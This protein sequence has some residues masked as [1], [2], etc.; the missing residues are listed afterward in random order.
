MTYQDICLHSLS[1]IKEVGQFIRQERL[2]F[3]SNTVEHKG[4]N[5]LVSYVDQ[6]AEKK[7]IE[8]LQK[9]LPGSAFLAEENTVELEE[10]EYTWIIDPLDGTTN[11]IHGLPS[12]GVSVALQHHDELVIGMV[13][14]PNADECFYAWKDGGAFLNGKSISVSDR[15]SLEHSLMA[16]G[17]PINNHAMIP[18]YLEIAEYFIKN[19]RGLRR[20]GSAAID[21]VYVACGRFDG[22]YEYNLKPWD[23]AAG[24][25]IV[26]E[27]GG[28]V[29]DFSGKENW[30]H[31]AEII[32]TS[33]HI[34]TTTYA[35]IKKIWNSHC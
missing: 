12:Y 15:P 25:L 24:A 30:L 20:L 11:F 14:E 35:E 5:D 2:N 21:L 16:T 17:F 27:A 23:V 28:T 33:N 22:F 1:V 32:A 29:S 3:D 6:T 13:Y 10:L 9:V 34:Y 7:L 18:A 26:K 19:T 31:G 8:G 4:K